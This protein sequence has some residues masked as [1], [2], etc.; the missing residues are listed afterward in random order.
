MINEF[1]REIGMQQQMQEIPKD[2]GSAP[3]DVI[4]AQL[5]NSN[6][7]HPQ[8]HQKQNGNAS[9]MSTDLIKTLLIMQPENKQKLKIKQHLKAYK[10]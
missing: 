3:N 7:D 2:P 5:K 8:E 9:T 6:L 1:I 4:K 10:I